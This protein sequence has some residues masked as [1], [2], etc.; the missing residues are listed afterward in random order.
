MDM[1]DLKEFDPF[2]C[3]EKSPYPEDE[4]TLAAIDAGIRDSDAGRVVS[5]EEV[6][7]LIPQWIAKYSLQ[8]PR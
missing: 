7:K 8:T 1:N 3:T 2:V 4:A 5:Y 6:L